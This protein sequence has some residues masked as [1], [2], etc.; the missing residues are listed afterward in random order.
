M[1]WS[2]LKVARSAPEAQLVQASV[3]LL[4]VADVLTDHRLV[5]PD[6]GDEIPPGPKMLPDEVAL[7]LAIDPSQ[8][9]GALTLEN[10]T[11]CDTAYFGGI[12]SIMWT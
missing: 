5:A 9:D 1:V 11:I 3:F 8:M 12:E 7:T 2:H 4:L 6:R 10:Y